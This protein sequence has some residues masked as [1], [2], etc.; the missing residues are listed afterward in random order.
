MLSRHL[1]ST[2]IAA[3]LFTLPAA[4]VN[5]DA[6][7][8]IAGALIG[9]I[10]GHAT[11]TQPK[12]TYRT[13]TKRSYKPRLPSTQEGRQIQSSLNYF[14]FDAG[15]VDGQL[16][17]KSPA[18]ISTYQAYMGYAATGQ[19][20]PYEQELLISSYNRA[21]AGGMQTSTLIAQTPDGT[22]GLLKRFRSEMA[23]QG[24]TMAAVSNVQTFGAV[25]GTTVVVAPVAP[26]AAQPAAPV[27]EAKVEEETPDALPNLFGGDTSQ[28]V[29][30][31][32]HCNKVSLLTNTNGGFITAAT[33]TDAAFAMSEQFCLARTYAI[34]DGEALAGALDATPQQIA[35]HCD[36]YGEQLAPHVAALSLKDRD[37]VIRDVSSFVLASGVPVQD[38][39]GTAKICLSVGY[40]TD[41]M[42]VAV[43]SA[44]L[45]ATLGKKGYGE[46]MGHHLRQGF[47]TSERTDLSLAW[48]DMGIEATEAG[49]SVF[50]PGQPERATLL[51]KASMSLGGEDAM[52]P[53]RDE[54][55]PVPASLPVLSITQ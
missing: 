2:A 19:L 49:Q 43:G 14:G 42:D 16:G 12:R 20:T 17:R 27:V 54:T 1:L 41:K 4:R 33:L 25:P 3:S 48:Y 38:L 36:A 55:A 11:R 35:A 50:A 32:S 6:G 34:S 40:R 39:E 37:S 51:R 45:L 9:G 18:A 13:T 31:A 28:V 53:S 15:G 23:G 26:V 10:V 22:R 29:S 8:F 47:G 52:V 46:L 21:Q 24:S 5:A 44:L 7:D 30:L